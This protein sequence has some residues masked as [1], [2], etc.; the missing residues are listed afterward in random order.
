MSPK[1]HLGLRFDLR[2]LALVVTEYR[3]W[4]SPVGVSSLTRTR[5]WVPVADMSALTFEERQDLR[6]FDGGI[7]IS[8]VQLG[9]GF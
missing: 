5:H 2:M 9:L 3:F 7:V 1:A 4:L 6:V 8:M